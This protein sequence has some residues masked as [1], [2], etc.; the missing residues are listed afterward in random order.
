MWRALA[1]I[2]YTR[3]NRAAVFDNLHRAAVADA[4]WR[5]MHGYSFDAD[6]AWG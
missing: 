3:G 2:Q 4:R 6:S 5:D 1:G